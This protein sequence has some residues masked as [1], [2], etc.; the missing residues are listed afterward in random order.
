[1]M[2]M[3]LYTFLFTWESCC[4]IEK[5]G[6]LNDTW[7]KGACTGLLLSAFETAEANVIPMQGERLQ[8]GLRNPKSL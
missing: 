7:S 8:N 5:A 4:P 6:L 1:M 2:K 3:Q